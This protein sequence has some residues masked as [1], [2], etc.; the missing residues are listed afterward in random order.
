MIDPQKLTDRERR[1]ESKARTEVRKTAGTGLM[2][3]T[4][5]KLTQGYQS[6]RGIIVC[7][8]CLST[9]PKTIM[10]RIDGQF[11]MFEKPLDKGKEPL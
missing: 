10:E 6:Y 11:L 5:C 2:F 9:W 4:R 8:T 3:C 7:E 1:A